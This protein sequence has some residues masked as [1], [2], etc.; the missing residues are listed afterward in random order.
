MTFRR[1]LLA[2]LLAIALVAPVT[3]VAQ[4]GG[5]VCEAATCEVRVAQPFV[6]FT[7]RDADA[8]NYQLFIDG[9]PSGL[10]STEVNGLVEFAHP[11]FPAIGT[12][13]LAIYAET[14][15]GFGQITDPVTVPVVR[16]KTKL[17]R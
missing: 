14:S 6:A 7:E 2:V 3:L 11:G 13:T 15:A 16:R 9:Q 10:P 1:L 4:T 17:R 12:H 5:Q 8:F